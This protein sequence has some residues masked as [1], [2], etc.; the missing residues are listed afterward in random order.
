MEA[1]LLENQKR[2]R[3][4]SDNRSTK[5]YEVEAHRGFLNE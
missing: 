2:Y 1:R 3:K 4:R 5:K